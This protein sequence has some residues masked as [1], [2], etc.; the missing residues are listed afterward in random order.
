MAAA[1]DYAILKKGGWM[2]QKQKD[3]FSLRIHVVGG[4]LDDVQLKTISDVAKKYG[5]GYVHLTARQ[6]VEIPWM[7]IHD[8]DAIKED[9]AKGGVKPSVCG[10]RV[11]TTTACQGSATCGHACIDTYALAREIDQRYFAREL[12]GKFKFGIT[13]CRNNCLKVEENDFGIKGAEKVSWKE[14][15]CIG[16]GLCV[17]SCRSGAITLKDGKITIDD[18][19][20]SYCGRCA[21]NC[22][23]DAYDVHPGYIVS[24]G[25]T[26]GNHIRRGNLIVPFI[27]KYETLIKLADAS[28]QFFDD[29][30][31]KGDRF[32]FCIDR[33]GQDKFN[34]I[35]HDI[36]VESEGH[37]YTEADV[38][39]I[40]A[41]R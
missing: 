12:P 3:K 13:G 27:S 24:F 26:F 2:R 41:G 18:S 22:P 40:Q 19:R 28:I 8:L 33:E 23:V 6:S 9:L 36:Y 34:R 5:Q 20:C 16:C 21:E 31:H 10:P 1:V 32:Q 30:A 17:K 39:K 35:M 11:R 38:E 25:G 29:Y 14:E 4:H 7:D 15:D 37:D